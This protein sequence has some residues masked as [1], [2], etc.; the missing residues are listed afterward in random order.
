MECLKS[1]W[2][3][4]CKSVVFRVTEHD[5]SKQPKSVSEYD[6]ETPESHTT[7]QPTVPQERVK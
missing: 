4:R 1:S 7:D 2:H 6:Q 5:E 3:L